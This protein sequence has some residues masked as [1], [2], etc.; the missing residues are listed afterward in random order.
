ME[1]GNM[2]SLDSQITNAD[3]GW[4]ETVVLI[5]KTCGEQFQNPSLQISPDRM[6]SDLKAIVKPV[7][8][9]KVRVITTSCLNI[10]PKN[11]IAIVSASR[12]VLGTFNAFSADPTLSGKDLFEKIF[13]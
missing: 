8:G 1:T 4:E 6:K 12:N 9:K 13:S 7:M 5:C 3:L 2:S 11:K 10:C